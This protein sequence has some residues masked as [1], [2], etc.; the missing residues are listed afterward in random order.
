M[1]SRSP[2]ATP[3]FAA[4]VLAGERKPGADPLARAAGVPSKILVPVGGVP[5]IDR[6]VDAIESTAAI[7]S[8]WLAGPDRAAVERHAALHE[9]IDD[10]RWRWLAPTESPASTAL[11]ALHAIGPRPV[12][13]TTADHAWLRPDIVGHFLS[14]AS[15]TGADLAIAFAR[16][17]TVRARFPDSRRTGWRFADGGY[18]GCNLF[19]FMTPQASAVARLWR[20]FEKDRKRPWRIV[21]GLGPGLLLRYVTGRLALDAGLAELG[22]RAGCRVAPVVLPFPEAAVDVDSVEDWQMVNRL[23]A[24]V[25]D[26]R[27]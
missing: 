20:A 17:D 13:V 22:R 14:A 7:D 11:T 26:S 8:R 2:D 4:V 10:G 6:V 19:A 24:A 23:S 3:P 5:V 21:A 15:A 12:L 27:S 25:A 9:R 18:C 16:L 1:T